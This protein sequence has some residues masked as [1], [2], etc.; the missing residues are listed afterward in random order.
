MRRLT[1]RSSWMDFRDTLARRESFTTSGALRGVERPEYVTLGQLPREWH[2][3]AL[4]AVYVVYSY[5]TPI[6]WLTR[7]GVWV[8]PDTR[9]SVTTSRHQ[10]RIAT[11]I[12]QLGE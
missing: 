10:G 8:M 5:R 1:T 7:T 3:S 11:A 2:T 12:S 6:A 4:A 9:Y